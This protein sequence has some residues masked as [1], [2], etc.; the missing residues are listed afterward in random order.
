MSQVAGSIAAASPSKGGAF[1]QA[2]GATAKP[3]PESPPPSPES[4]KGSEADIASIM[5]RLAHLE[6]CNRLGNVELKKE[7]KNNA[8]LR[9]AIA[10][11]RHGEGEEGEWREE[12]SEVDE[13]E[14][15]PETGMPAIPASYMMT[16]QKPPGNIEEHPWQ[17]EWVPAAAVRSATADENRWWPDEGERS[18]SKGK[19]WCQSAWGTTWQSP[20]Q[21]DPWAEYSRGQQNWTRGHQNWS[22]SSEEGWHGQW[23]GGWGSQWSQPLRQPDRKDI[24][25]PAKYAGDITKWLQWSK[26]FIRFLR[27]QDWRWTQLLEKIQGLRGRP[28]TA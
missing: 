20:Q 24:D 12:E 4:L 1:T 14:A 26:A 23:N 9:E 27:R 25:R 22:G 2:A 7:K 8:R 21:C 10:A 28:V 15:A 19:Q 18:D 11:A 3:V 5:A 13:V 16:P 17:D 6:E